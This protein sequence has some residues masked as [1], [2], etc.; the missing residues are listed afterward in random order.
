MK[1]SLISS[2][3]L[4]LGLC[5]AP[6]YAQDEVVAQALAKS[7]IKLNEAG[8]T[9][10]ARGL[11][12]KSLANDENC[13]DALLELGKI[14]EQEGNAGS[15][16]DFYVQAIRVLGKDEA[17][18]RAKITEAKNRLAKLN[19]YANQLTGVMGDYAGDLGAALKKNP[20]SLT[21]DETYELNQ[22]IKLDRYVTADKLPKFER[23]ENLTPPP[24]KSTTAEERPRKHRPMDDEDAPPPAKNDVPLE[25]EKALKSQTSGWSKITGVWKKKAENVYE[26]TNGRLEAEK[27]NGAVQ[28]T[29][30]GGG[31]GMVEVYVRNGHQRYGGPLGSDSSYGSG[32]G[33]RVK[34]AQVSIM[35]PYNYSGMEYTPYK[36]KDF[37]ITSPKTNV[38]IT[39]DGNKMEYL[40]NGA[41][42]KNASYPVAAEG[43]F[44]VAVTGTVTIELPQAA[45]R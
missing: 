38:V 15:A 31:K 1:L 42:V 7:A 34:G 29:V 5:T 21:K 30:Q 45:G 40:I 23:G 13:A 27:L 4:A 37:P 36:E 12:L 43:T 18:N 28:C 14:L 24:A 25:V 6:L 9:E 33:F 16:A 26:V 8:Q 44:V 10:K 2:C 3:A 39:I 11:C 35:A 41:K 32:Y 22:N 17:T 20:D 19:P